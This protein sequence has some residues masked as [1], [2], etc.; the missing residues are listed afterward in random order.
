MGYSNLGGKK[1]GLVERLPTGI[2]NREWDIFQLPNDPA[3]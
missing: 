2:K 3:D 1:R